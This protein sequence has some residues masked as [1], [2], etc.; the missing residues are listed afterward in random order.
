[1]PKNIQIENIFEMIEKNPLVT[2]IALC[3][4]H[5]KFIEECLQSV[6]NQTYTNIELIIVDDFSTDNSCEKILLFSSKHPTVKII[7]N[8][9]NI[10]NCRSF[11][12]ALQI[13]K[14]KYII[15]LS[16]DDVLLSDR[17]TE[18]VKLMETSEQI[19]VIF[20]DSLFIDEKSKIY[21]SFFLKKFREQSLKPIGNVYEKVLQKKLFMMPVTMM[22]RRTVFE[23]LGGYDETLAY[24]D[25]DF[26]V[27][28][29]RMCEYGYVPKVLSYQRRVKGSLST[30]ACLRKN[31]LIVTSVIVAQ[32]ALLLN[33]TKAEN[34]ALVDYLKLIM[35]KCAFTENFESGEKVLE[36]FRSLNGKH[37]WK[38]QIYAKV[39]EWRIPLNFLYVP[40][41]RLRQYILLNF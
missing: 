32:K 11:N 13:S 36:M 24:E 7:L 34:E 23:Q 10:G 38:T 3:Y 18:Q 25:T 5:E 6:V 15:D 26:W 12:Q 22:T 31:K 27:R 41:V 35:P 9:K 33:K 21:N 30:K 8:K 29:S 16:T 37:D 39:I 19:G 28:S 1:M 20:S 40:S 14:G 4:N 17:I 2:V